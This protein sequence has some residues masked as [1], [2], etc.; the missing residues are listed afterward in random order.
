MD[1]TVE[2][3]LPY[4]LW[5]MM[6]NTIYDFSLVTAPQNLFQMIYVKGGTA[7]AACHNSNCRIEKGHL[8]CLH[9]GM[10]VLIHASEQ[11]FIFTSFLI[12]GA[13]DS[14][15]V[16]SQLSSGSEAEQQIVKLSHYCQA[17][18]PGCAVPWLNDLFQVLCHSEPM[19]RTFFHQP[20]ICS[21]KKMIDKHCG[22]QLCLEQFAKELHTNKYKTLKILRHV[23]GCRRY[24]T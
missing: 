19:A 5:G 17:A 10:T 24:S 16:I 4:R 6:E 13:S 20:Q 3:N 9:S 1:S 12:S 8:L 15:P 14:I 11:P 21:L 7:M 22:E 23:M 2:R 18:K